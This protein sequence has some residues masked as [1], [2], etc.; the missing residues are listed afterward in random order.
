M[1]RASAPRGDTKSAL[2]AGWAPRKNAFLL[3]RGAGL[4]EAGGGRM[5]ASHGRVACAFGRSKTDGG[6]DTQAADAKDK[7]CVCL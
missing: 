6:A 1:F 3:D 5:H 2:A 7:V 4:H